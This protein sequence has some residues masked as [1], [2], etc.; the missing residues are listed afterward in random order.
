MNCTTTSF[1]YFSSSTP[2]ALSR[3]ANSICYRPNEFT[4]K[5]DISED[6][7]HPSDTT[8]SSTR[9]SPHACLAFRRAA[10]CSLQQSHDPLQ[11]IPRACLAHR[12]VARGPFFV[13]V[14]VMCPRLLHHA[15][16]HLLGMATRLIAGL[17]KPAINAGLLSSSR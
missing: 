13:L 4:V 9:P 3:V 6:N 10:M 8:Q 14:R 1:A 5:V 16:C 11:A 12:R 7:V 15:E 2:C 17:Q